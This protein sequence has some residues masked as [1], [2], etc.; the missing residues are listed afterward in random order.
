MTD[1]RVTWDADALSGDW[2]LDAA[3]DLDGTQD[4]V[5]AIA[6]SLFTHRTADDDDVLPAGGTDRRGW[7]G[8]HEAGPIHG[9]TPVGSRLWLLHR[10]K[11][12]EETRRRAE[13]Y[14]GEALDWV[15]AERLAER[16]EV[17]VAWFG[18]GRLG[19]EIVLHRGPAGSL[20]VRFE[21]LWQEIA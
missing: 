1:I 7:W 2:L 4:L 15:V 20:A 9:G 19:A 18:V 10:E 6:V 17:T 16:V 14:V 5:S 11:H 8:D 3:G 13:V 12:V 21:S